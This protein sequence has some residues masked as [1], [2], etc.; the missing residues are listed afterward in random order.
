MQT[1]NR[2]RHIC[3]TEQD[4]STPKAPRTYDTRN[5]FASCRVELKTIQQCGGNE[6]RCDSGF[7]G[8]LKTFDS[9]RLAHSGKPRCGRPLPI[10]HKHFERAHVFSHRRHDYIA[11]TEPATGLIYFYLAPCSAHHL[12]PA[13][14]L[15]PLFV[16]TCRSSYVCKDYAALVLFLLARRGLGPSEPTQSRSAKIPGTFQ[17]LDRHFKG[18]LHVATTKTT[19]DNANTLQPPLHG[20]LFRCLTP[21][22]IL[23]PT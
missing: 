10:L 15:S 18:Y 3:I 14:A 5:L 6:N 1:A 22:F 7:G 20:S 21:P 17:E 12:S 13:V 11:L 4:H 9:V 19:L 8:I 16:Y 23:L 2:E